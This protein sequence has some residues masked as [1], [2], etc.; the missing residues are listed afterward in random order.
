MQ[1]GG[2]RTAYGGRANLRFSGISLESIGA[3][4]SSTG[5]WE[6][7]DD[8]EDDADYDPNNEDDDYESYPYFSRSDRAAS[9]AE[10]PVSEPQEAGVKLLNS[11]EFGRITSHKASQPVRLARSP[12]QPSVKPSIASPRIEVVQVSNRTLEF[13]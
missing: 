4:L 10:A 3:L 2:A 11:G 5:Q 12:F 1:T 7:D 6:D 13:L 9:P 8:D